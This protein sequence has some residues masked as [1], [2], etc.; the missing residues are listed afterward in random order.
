[1]LITRDFN[2]PD[3]DWNNWTAKNNYSADFLECLRENFLHQMVES[4]TRVRNNK[5]PSTL[6]L[7]LVNDN[8]NIGSI[9][10]LDPVGASDHCVLKFECMCYFKG[11]QGCRAKKYCSIEFF[12]F[13]HVSSQRCP[14]QHIS[15]SW[16]L[17]DH[18]REIMRFQLP[19]FV[20]N[21]KFKVKF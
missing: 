3:I 11:V 8:N 1:M 10:Y 19:P 16:S 20:E 13:F 5:E 12:Y 15:F 6:D 2:F 7:V 17:T 9:E 4:P 18:P 21:V 14:L